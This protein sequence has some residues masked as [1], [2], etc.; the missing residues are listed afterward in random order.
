MMPGSVQRRNKEC[1]TRSLLKIWEKKRKFKSTAARQHSMEERGLSSLALFVLDK[2]RQLFRGGLG[3][4]A[5][6]LHRHA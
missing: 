5:P 4:A 2:R 3:T 1:D 6:H